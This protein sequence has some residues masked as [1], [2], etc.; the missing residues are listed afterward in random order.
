M[1]IEKVVVGMDFSDAA[2]GAATWVHEAFA[3]EARLIFV[4]AQESDRDRFLP[5]ATYPTSIEASLH[6]AAAER[7]REIGRLITGRSTR[8]EVRNGR[9]HDVIGEIAARERADLI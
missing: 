4:H 6:E 1:N 2:I 7:A 3:M 8:V 9:A 5:Q